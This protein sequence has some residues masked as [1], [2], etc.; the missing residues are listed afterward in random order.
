MAII[1][2]DNATMANLDSIANEELKQYTAKIFEYA[3]DMRQNALRIA[4]TM[5]V[6]QEHKDTLLTDYDCKLE[7]FGEKVLGL[8]RS[9]TFAYAKVGREFLDSDGHALIFEPDNASYT[10]TQLQALLPLGREL[11]DRMAK[12]GTISPTMT[13]AQ[14]KAAVKDNDPKKDAKAAAKSKREQ[15]QAHIEAEKAKAEEMIHGK[16]THTITVAVRPDGK[17]IVMCN[18]EDI[19]STNIGKYLIKN[20]K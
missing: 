1:T 5:A 17:H 11:S 18:G 14:L 16:V 10:M 8:K 15:K 12:D 7:N 13:V 3:F 6:I 19:T 4:A 20:Y 2:V 9:Q